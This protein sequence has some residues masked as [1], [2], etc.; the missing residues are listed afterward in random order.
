M[1]VKVKSTL[2][3]A[4]KAQELSE[5]EL[6]PLTSALNAGGWS[7]PHASRFTPQNDPVPIVQ[8][9]GWAPEPVWTG[10]VEYENTV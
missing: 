10:A 9:T 7:T 4:T 3:E 2:E 8:D 1:L 6:Y 5:V